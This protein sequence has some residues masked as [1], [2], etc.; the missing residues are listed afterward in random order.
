MT[1]DMAMIEAQKTYL[2]ANPEKANPYY[3]AGFILVGNTK[4]LVFDKPS[5]GFSGLMM[6]LVGGLVAL[7]GWFFYKRRKK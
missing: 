2:T 5:T 3:W 4:G 6:T 1:K 7:F